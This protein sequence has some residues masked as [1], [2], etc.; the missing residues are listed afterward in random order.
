MQTVNERLMTPVKQ[1]AP[2]PCGRHA[3]GWR[4]CSLVQFNVG[5][6]LLNPRRIQQQSVSTYK[7]GTAV[8]L[9]FFSKLIG[10]KCAR[11]GDSHA[12][13]VVGQAEFW[14]QKHMNSERVARH[15]GRDGDT[16]RH[17]S[18]IFCKHSLHIFFCQ[19][20]VYITLREIYPNVVTIQVLQNIS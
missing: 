14:V 15:R 19:H 16:H 1:Q 5:K 3:G 11:R 4:W 17:E 13:A 20:T 18:A 12:S 2:L 7:W 6:E 9:I 10:W 8:H